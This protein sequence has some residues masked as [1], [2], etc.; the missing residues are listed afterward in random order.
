MIKCNNIIKQYKNDNFDII[1]KTTKEHNQHWPQT[2][3]DPYKILIIGGTGSV[4]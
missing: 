3:D 1:K 2:S 4:M